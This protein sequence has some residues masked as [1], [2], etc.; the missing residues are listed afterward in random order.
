[1]IRTLSVALALLLVSG[2]VSTFMKKC[3][4]KDARYSKSKMGRQ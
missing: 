2:Y 1:M 4:G 3:I